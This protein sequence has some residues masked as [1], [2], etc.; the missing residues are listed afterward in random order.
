MALSPL[1]S[2]S[3]VHS[4]AKERAYA[5]IEQDFFPILEQSAEQDGDECRYENACESVQEGGDL[6]GVIQTA[7]SVDQRKAARS[8][9]VHKIVSGFNTGVLEKNGFLNPDYKWIGAFLKDMEYSNDDGSTLFFNFLSISTTSEINEFSEDEKP[10]EDLT[11]QVFLY[12]VVFSDSN[13]N[14]IYDMGE[15]IG[16]SQLNINDGDL[17]VCAM[18]DRAGSA[19]LPLAKGAY[20]VAVS[21]DGE[22]QTLLSMGIDN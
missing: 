15:G 13:G 8:I 10:P 12:C 19:T 17:N 20:E 11:S 1:I 9:L 6:F 21:V 22:I 16:D 4:C 14:G 18:T 5:K 2:D 3:R 7:V